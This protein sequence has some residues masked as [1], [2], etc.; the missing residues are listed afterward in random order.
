[1]QL[2][3]PDIIAEV[4]GLSVTA[5]AIGLV[6]GMAL[7]LFGWWGHRFWIV[8]SGTVLAGLLGLFSTQS[9][10]VQPLVIGLL[11][12][13]TA[14]VLA[15]ALARVLAFAAGGIAGSMLVAALAPTVNEPLICFFSGGLI[16]VLLFRLWM[17]ALTSLAGTVLMAYSGLLLADKLGKV[18][19]PA[20]MDKSPVLLNWACIGITLLGLVLQFLLDRWR[21][22]RAK[23]QEKPKA[24]A[25]PKP[26]PASAPP[27]PAWKKW[28]PFRK[29]G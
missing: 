1:M 26:A 9:P 12:A 23:A 24:G 10:T 17:M 21:G 16:G 13:L 25:A 11:L 14:G 4:R 2:L 7:W 19:A 27:P 22:R 3:A 15:L 5:C 6:L 8:L 29:A 20:L 28:V 18:D